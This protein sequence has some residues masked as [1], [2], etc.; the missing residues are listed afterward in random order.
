MTE[1]TFEAFGTN[2]YALL[3]KLQLALESSFAMS[4]LKNKVRAAMLSCTRVIDVS[5]AV[6][7]GPEERA[8][9][10]ATFT[11]S[12]VVEVSV[13]RIERVDIEVHTERH[14]E[15]ITI[16]PPIREQ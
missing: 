3:S 6:G 2:A 10:T 4:F 1:V 13:P 11:H 16:E 9:F 14:V 5:A 8:R 15:L 12:H 7:G